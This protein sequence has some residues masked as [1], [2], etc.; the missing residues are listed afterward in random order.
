MKKQWDFRKHLMMGGCI[1]IVLAVFL[2]TAISSL[3]FDA[4]AAGNN[5]A[6]A[7]T[8]TFAQTACQNAANEVYQ[9]ALGKCENERESNQDSCESDA[10]AELDSSLKDCQ[11]Q[12]DARQAV[13]EEVGQGPYLPTGIAPFKPFSLPDDKGYFPLKVGTKYTYKSYDTKG[14]IIETDVVQVTNKTRTLLGVKCRAV[15]DTVYKGNAQ[16]D[17]LE[18]TTDWYA[19]DRF[20]NKW[21][22]G[23]IAQQFDEEGILIAIDGSWT[24]GV[25]GAKPGI[26]IY[27]KP[28]DH[29]GQGYRQEFALGEAEDDS[30]NVDFVTLAYL[31]KYAYFSANFPK[32]IKIGSGKVILHTQ[33][34]SAL[35]PASVLEGQFEDKFY[36]PGVGLILTVGPDG[37]Q[38]VLVT[39]E[40]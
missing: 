39:I 17:K 31:N 8:S 5:D 29:I 32:S 36:A 30:R 24:A 4:K 40:R 1:R 18:D 34:F 21:Y 25:E 10:K 3:N 6:C 28:E 27:A 23:E 9:L 26:L 11:D 13:C 7:E 33:D 20:G 19:Q 2:V 12:Y 16:V 14:N 15:Q 37:T 38:E 22:F 35:E